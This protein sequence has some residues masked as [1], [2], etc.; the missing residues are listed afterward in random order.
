MS[1][2]GYAVILGSTWEY[3]LVLVQPKASPRSEI[4]SANPRVQYY[5]HFA[6]QWRNCWWYLDVPQRLLW[7]VF[8]HALNGRD[9]VNVSTIN[10]SSSG[11]L[12]N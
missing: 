4:V 9:G 2:F 8:C 5:R 3:A 7:H 1:I 10:H 6:Q 11:S 12:C